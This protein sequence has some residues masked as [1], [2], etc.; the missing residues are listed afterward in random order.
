MVRIELKDVSSLYMWIVI[1]TYQGI[2]QGRDVKR[3]CR[4]LTSD[5]CLNLF[6]D[7]AYRT[8]DYINKVA[9]LVL[10]MLWMS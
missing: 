1:I 7:F 4:D 2:F 3:S 9:S 6:S 10:L 8:Q 5:S